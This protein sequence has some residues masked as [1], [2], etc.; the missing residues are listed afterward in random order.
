M[1]GLR[2]IGENRGRNLTTFF[3]NDGPLSR[4]LQPI[5]PRSDRPLV[6]SIAPHIAQSDYRSKANAG[7][8]GPR[9]GPRPGALGC[10]PVGPHPPPPANRR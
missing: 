1:T 2:K 7:I 6:Y 8:L 4:L 3:R 9:T 10:N 5:Q